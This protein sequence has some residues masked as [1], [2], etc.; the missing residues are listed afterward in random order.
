MSG[1]IRRVL[2][3]AVVGLV[4]TAAHAG[5]AP[6]A[7]EHPGPD[8]RFYLATRTVP[9]YVESGAHG[10]ALWSAVQSFYRAR[11]YR[12][13]WVTG[14]EVSAEAAML[15]RLVEQA[16]SEGLDGPH[17]RREPAGPHAVTAAFNGAPES[18]ADA[19]QDVQ[20]TYVFLRYASGL[21]GRFDPK[22]AGPFWLTRARPRDL[23][24]WLDQSL[25]SGDVVA[26][27]A[28][29]SPAHPAYGAL[30]ACLA[31]YRGIARQGGWAALP[32]RL[33]LRR[34]SRS[35]QVAALRTRL[36]VEGD[37]PA[38]ASRPADTYDSSLVD[39]VKR[40]EQRHGLAADGILDAA[41]VAALNVTV[42]ERIGQIELNLERWRW[43][44][45]DLGRRYLMVNV[46]SF[47]LTAYE[48]GHPPLAMKVVTGKPE[49]P[50][51][52]FGGDMTTVVFSPFWNVP[53]T[54][55]E[56]EII[57]AV[58]RDPGYLTRHN[59]ELVRGTQV[60]GPAALRR[61]D[62]QI[63]QR[64]GTSNSLGLVKFVFPNPFGVYLHGTPA[65][66]LFARPLRA[67][68]HGCVR[69]EKPYEL[70]RWVL[71]GLPRWTPSAIQAAMRSGREGQLALPQPIPVYI[72]YQT[73]QASPDGTAFFWP[74]V[75]GH[76][77]AQMPLMPAPSSVPLVPIIAAAPLRPALDPAPAAGN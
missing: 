39:G 36:A 60:V 33:A 1:I 30:K 73:V 10:E 26:A 21:S 44:P 76:D 64:P 69:V 50:T 67:F 46:P 28:A 34:G 43:L 23:A 52:V 62:V 75:Y 38:G 47:R 65:G 31:R 54:I 15:I 57:P 24:A 5:D 53:P 9:G 27:F 3:Y 7:D 17:D 51:P 13:A 61:G 37:L 29:L 35:P 6:A 4:A 11:D 71:S 20:L 22:A 16:E 49:S 14:G 68:S 32:P 70:A 40:F 74:D 12:L 8:A 77:A 45:A 66:A 41:T 19:V 72:T 55:A 48:E 63:R 59:L 56:D 25:R 2:F 42:E 18:D 58:L